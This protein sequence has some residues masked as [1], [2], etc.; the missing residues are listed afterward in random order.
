[1]LERVLKTA[2]GRK[3]K[4]KR[5]ER[6]RSERAKTR[7]DGNDLKE[8]RGPPSPPS[9][10]FSFLFS[11]SRLRLLFPILFRLSLSSRHPPAFHALDL[12]APILLLFIPDLGQSRSRCSNGHEQKE[13]EKKTKTSSDTLNPNFFKNIVA[14]FSRTLFSRSSLSA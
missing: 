11:D 7:P 2:A 4:R 10:L 8:F 14:F 1:M 3:E 12:S 9:F 13:K 5:R 6:R